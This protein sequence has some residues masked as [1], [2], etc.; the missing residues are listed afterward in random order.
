MTA[1]ERRR[2]LAELRKAAVERA[3][4]ADGQ[5]RRLLDRSDACADVGDVLEAART[6]DAA[7]VWASLA[8]A[9]EA[10]VAR[11][12]REL[13]RPPRREDQAIQEGD[14]AIQVAY[15]GPPL[16]PPGM[17]PSTSAALAE[18][19]ANDRRLRG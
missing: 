17:P 16:P 8:I 6:L 5:A 2:R 14:Q 13:V 10:A 18:R 1:G 4:A 9:G 12:D 15:H 7:Q 3:E 11:L 19:I